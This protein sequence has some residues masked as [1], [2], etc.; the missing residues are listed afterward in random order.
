MVIQDAQDTHGQRKL[1]PQDWNLHIVQPLPY[2]HL[3]LRE[4][5]SKLLQLWRVTHK[6]GDALFFI[7]E[8]AYTYLRSFPYTGG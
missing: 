5:H 4:P 3:L 2:G 8:V 6:I 7:G 1:G